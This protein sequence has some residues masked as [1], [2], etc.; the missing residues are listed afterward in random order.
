[1]IA[2]LFKRRIQEELMQ[3][4]KGYQLMLRENTIELT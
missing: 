2:Q 3:E 4:S 1:M